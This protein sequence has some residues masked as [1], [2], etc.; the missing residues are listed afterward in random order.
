MS[1]LVKIII[2]II[3]AFILLSLCL[4]KFQPGRNRNASGEGASRQ[5]AA[6]EEAEGE[7]GVVD[8]ESRTLTLINHS[9]SIQF[10]FDDKTS[11]VQAGRF[12]RPASI[13]P[14]ARATVKYQRGG[15]GLVAREIVLTP[16]SPY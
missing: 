12:V 10:S 16:S 5:A 13:K 4:Y 3:A 14:G 6:V 1:K 7:I 2:I 8:E 11:V 9:S 15:R